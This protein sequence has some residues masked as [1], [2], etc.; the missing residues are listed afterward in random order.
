MVEEFGKSNDKNKRR[1]V[2]AAKKPELR[3]RLENDDQALLAELT[4]HFDVP[5]V[6]AARRAIRNEVGRVREG[7]Q[8]DR[9]DTLR[10]NVVGLQEQVAHLGRRVEASIE[11][12]R[13]IEKQI[14]MAVSEVT[15][16]SANTSVRLLA[17]IETM[18]PDRSSA[19]QA[20]I[21]E[22]LKR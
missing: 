11:I 2:S 12:S 14:L 21:Q 20:K 15:N 10:S 16:I 7:F 22:I 18:T 17:M 3:L 5:A 1:I 19:L 4:L 9:L 6:E 13:S 8:A